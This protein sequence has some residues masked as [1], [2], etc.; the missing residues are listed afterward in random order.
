MFSLARGVLVTSRVRIFVRR[1]TIIRAKM[2][3][4]F[5]SD[6]AD[7]TFETFSNRLAMVKSVYRAQL[8]EKE[9]L[10]ADQP[11]NLSASRIADV[12]CRIC[13]E[14]ESTANKFIAPCLCT[15]SVKYV[16]EECLKTWIVSQADDCS[17]SKCELCKYAFVMD[18]NISTHCSLKQALTDGL[19]Q[20]LFIPMMLI[21]L[22]MLC[23]ILFL[24]LDK[25]I[26]GDKVKD[27]K[28]YLISLFITCLMSACVIVYLI[29]NAFRESCCAERLDAWHILT[30]P[31]KSVCSSPIEELPSK[32][33]ILDDE[34][35]G[36]ENSIPARLD[37][38][39][40][41]VIPD[42]I[43]FRGRLLSTPLLEPSLHALT[44]REGRTTVFATPAL[45]SSITAR[46]LSNRLQ[47]SS[48]LSI[49]GRSAISDIRV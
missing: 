18:F 32:F 14:P 2:H 22:C 49:T 48:R 34:Q 28:G 44:R 41:I 6:S 11:A 33:S 21:V 43:R 20:C 24:L 17:V 1:I 35:T 47:S 31:Q 3:E 12:I 25:F 30:K 26:Q 39:P 15:G 37:Q 36:I 13:L 38:P 29:V 42:K 19:S 8:A 45:H 10:S 7:E 5:Y 16:H 4:H 46:E 23:L 40:V 27:E 9:E